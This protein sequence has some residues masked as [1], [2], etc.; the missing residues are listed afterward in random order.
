MKPQFHTAT[1]LFVKRM[2]HYRLLAASSLH[3]SWERVSK[4][5]CRSSLLPLLF[6]EL[7]VTDELELLI[8]AMAREVAH[9]HRCSLATTRCQIHGLVARARGEYRAA[10]APYGD[11][12]RGLCR[13]PPRTPT[14]D[15]CCIAWHASTWSRSRG[16]PMTSCLAK[17]QGAP[18]R[19]TA[20]L[21]AS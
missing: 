5:N 17:A 11:D 13:L 21:Y 10:E 18:I 1:R 15:T 12:D 2:Y 19:S 20:Q 6:K 4:C 3:N 7:W 14:S 16:R 9:H 8:A